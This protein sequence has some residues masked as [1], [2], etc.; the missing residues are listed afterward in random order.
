MAKCCEIEVRDE[1]SLWGVD[2]MSLHVV[3][4]L[5]GLAISNVVKL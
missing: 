5:T 3:G 4:V 2:S 1:L